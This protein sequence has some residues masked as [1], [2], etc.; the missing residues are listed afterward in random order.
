M[1]IGARIV[2]VCVHHLCYAGK[3]DVQT[4][5]IGFCIVDRDPRFLLREI[6]RSLLL[7]FVWEEQSADHGCEFRVTS[8]DLLQVRVV[9]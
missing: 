1:K 5:A 3:L 8:R 6:Y 2:S 9:H 4:V 7:I